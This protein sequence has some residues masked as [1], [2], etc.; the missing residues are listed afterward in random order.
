MGVNHIVKDAG[1]SKNLEI[2]TPYLEGI[3]SVK[4]VPC[5]STEVN[6]KSQDNHLCKCDRG[7]HLNW[8]PQDLGQK[9]WLGI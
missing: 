9:E 8:E 7:Q 1:L 5:S 4:Q 3:S 2:D 6:I